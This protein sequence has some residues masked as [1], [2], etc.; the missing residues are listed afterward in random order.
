MLKRHVASCFLKS[1][2]IYSC[3]SVCLC[4]VW[5]E[6]SYRLT[7]KISHVCLSCFSWRSPAC[8]VA[9]SCRVCQALREWV[10]SLGRSLCPGRQPCWGLAVTREGWHLV[11]RWL[12]R[13]A[14]VAGT[15]VGTGAA[16]AGAEPHRIAPPW[17]FHDPSHWWGVDESH[18]LGGGRLEVAGWVH[19][20]CSP[21]T[22]CIPF[23]T[24]K[25][26]NHRNTHLYTLHSIQNCM[27]HDLG[28][29]RTLGSASVLLLYGGGAPRIGGGTVA[30]EIETCCCW[31]HQLVYFEMW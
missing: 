17:S 14:G 9:V 10:A 16:G 26:P 12:P 25:L 13:C 3:T 1:S 8:C 15:G 6:A 31:N 27:M 28:N 5:H 7:S 4:T 23:T 11:A 24:C 22:P 19:L 29:M 18:H 20:G 30:S 2:V 21:E